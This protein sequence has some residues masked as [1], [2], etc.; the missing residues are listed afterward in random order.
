[1]CLEE[2][3]VIHDGL[4][5]QIGCLEQISSHTSTKGRHQKEIFRAAVQTKGGHI[6]GRRLLNCQFLGG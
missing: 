6:C 4:V 2:R 5:Q 3:G 1:M